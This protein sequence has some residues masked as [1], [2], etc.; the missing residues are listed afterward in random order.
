MTSLDARMNELLEQTADWP[1]AGRIVYIRI[2]MAK[3]YTAIHAR[4]RIAEV[5]AWEARWGRGAPRLLK[6]GTLPTTTDWRERAPIAP[7]V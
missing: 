2:E 6:R 1:E 5:A 7:H 4:A 3:V